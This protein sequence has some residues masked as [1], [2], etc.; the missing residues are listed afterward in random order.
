MEHSHRDPAACCLCIDVGT[1]PHE[2]LDLRD[3]G[4][5]RP[6]WDARLSLKKSTP[7]FGG[8]LDRFTHGAHFVLG[9]NYAQFDGP[10]LAHLYPALA[11]HRLPLV[12]TL[13]LSPIAFPQNPYHR[14]VKDYKLCTT[15]RNDSVH[16]AALAHRLFLDQCAALQERAARH[17]EEALC[18]HFLLVAETAPSTGLGALW[19]AWRGGERRP[20]LLEA[21]R[22]WMRATK[23]KACATAQRRVLDEWLSDPSWHQ[24]LAYTLAWL[25]VAGGNSVLP[26][27]V[28]HSHP[29][30]REVTPAWPRPPA[31][32]CP[33]RPWAN[34][35]APWSCCAQAPA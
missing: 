34:A 17:P 6:D 5:F 7:D 12:D 33:T 32:A 25:R 19:Q 31:S 28:G 18:L 11:L 35:C 9:H 27:W 15:A 10:V 21:Q 24:A 16:D 22:A 29:R 20:S 23:G 4:A 14:L 30:T 2:R 3:V 13:E 26:P 1:A 8:R